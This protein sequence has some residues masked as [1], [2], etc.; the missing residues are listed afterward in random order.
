MKIGFIGAGNMAGAIIRGMV[1]GGFHGNDILVYDTDSTKLVELF[2]DCGIRICTSSEE[3]AGGAEALVLAIKPQVFPEVLPQLAEVLQQY[4]PLVISI[5]AGKTIAVIEKML[6]TDLPLVR[7]MPNINAKVGE[8]MS[9]FCGN[10]FIG[11]E[12]RA[13][14]RMI[15]EAVGEV[16][17]LQEKLFS[18]F[19]VLASCSPAFTLM[20]VDA[21][22]EAGVKYG[23]PKTLALKI[24]SQAVLGTT[25]LLQETETHPRVLM[26]QVC[27]PAGTTIEGVCA[28]QREGFEAAVLAATDASLAKDMSL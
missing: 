18:A 27:S 15:F 24:A 9:A 5:A 4:Q 22:A 6:E 8:A 16:I 21:L 1:S 7:V 2:E 14:V 17:E 19:S 3:V 13:I 23:I 25:R 28:L 11:D 26:D 20:Y 12:H 10:E